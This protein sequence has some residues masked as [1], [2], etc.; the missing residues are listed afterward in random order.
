MSAP[1]PE[2]VL[3][4]GEARKYASIQAGGDAGGDTSQQ[5]S[6]AP[7]RGRDGH[8]FGVL[9]GRKGVAELKPHRTLTPM[10]PPPPPH[11]LPHHHPRPHTLAP[12]LGPTLVL[13]LS[14]SLQPGPPPTVCVRPYPVRGR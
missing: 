4:S 13:T 6:L 12:S 7:L 14:L 9:V 5:Y 3:S 8:L 10:D 11:P 1:A 2:Q